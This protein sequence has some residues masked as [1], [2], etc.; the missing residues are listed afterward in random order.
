[1]KNSKYTLSII[2]P[3]RNRNQYA[4]AA[5][6][7]VLEN[8]TD[9]VQVV[10]QDNSDELGLLDELRESTNLDR[11]KYNHSSELLSFVDNFSK[12]VEL[13]DGEYLCMIGDDDGINPEIEKIVDWAKLKGVQ[14]ISP[15]IKLNYIWP[16]SGIKYYKSDNGNLTINDFDLKSKFYNTDNEIKKLLRSGGQNYLKF[17]MV[18]IYHGIVKKSAM[19]EVKAITGKYFGGLSPDIYSSIALS[20]VIEK[21]LKINYPL[22]IPG[23]CRKSGAG[24]SSTGRHHGNLEDAPQ[25]Q[26]HLNYQWSDLV[27]RFYSVETL[28]ADS[29]I[30]AFTDMKRFDLIEKFDVAQ[31]SVYCYL[32]YREF[33]SFTNTNLDNYYKINNTNFLIKKYNLLR[34]LI[35]GPVKDQVERVINRV[36]RNRNE[37]S[38]YENI[39]NISAAAAILKKYLEDKNVNVY[40]SIDKLL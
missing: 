12:G 30:A 14:A 27:P 9:K 31:L 4:I 16:N 15:E 1:M 22:T 11:V 8:T 18:K 19:E 29:A 38:R 33:N 3:T 17:N 10:L 7:Q 24:H 35:N 37:I 2:I 36:K 28:W 34:G 39:G 13:A 23:V 32:G 26:G 40:R 6:L 25:L 21:V 20:L 5:T